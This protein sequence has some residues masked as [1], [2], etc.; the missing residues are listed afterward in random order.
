MCN[1]PVSELTPDQRVKH[2]ATILAFGVRRYLHRLRRSESRP[3]QQSP[4][5]VPAGLEVL[6]NPRLSVSQ[7][8]AI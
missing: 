1:Q 7:S 6:G 8:I 4:E 2:L 5:S 3:E